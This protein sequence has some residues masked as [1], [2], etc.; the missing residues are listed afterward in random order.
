MPIG[1]ATFVAGVPQPFVPSGGQ[2]W[3]S[4]DDHNLL[5]A[6]LRIGSLAVLMS[7]F[8]LFAGTPLAI[9]YG[10][11][12]EARAV[13]AFRSL[14][15]IILGLGA[16][17]AI[18]D[19][20]LSLGIAIWLREVLRM[21][22]PLLTIM[23]AA[24]ALLMASGTTYLL[25]TKAP[26]IVDGA[27][28]VIALRDDH[29][30]LWRLIDDVA[31]RCRS[32]PPDE[33]LLVPTLE[34][35]TCT[36]RMLT[37]DG[38]RQL[39]LSMPLL[40]VIDEGELR[41]LATYCFAA[42]PVSLETVLHLRVEMVR[43]QP[44]AGMLFEWRSFKP[45]DRVVL[46]I[47]TPLLGIYTFA[48]RCLHVGLSRV[49]TRRESRADE[50]VSNIWG[51]AATANALLKWIELQTIWMLHIEEIWRSPQ[52]R[53]PD[54]AALRSLFQ[55]SLTDS[56]AFERVMWRDRTSPAAPYAARLRSLG[57]GDDAR[58][59]ANRPWRCVGGPSARNL[60]EHPD[61]VE[62]RLV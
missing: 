18:L 37:A 11:R 3:L 49:N 34:L 56:P 40:S 17:A 43:L 29:P 39:R 26:R 7:G 19:A 61:V 57:A 32:K 53:L 22:L 36:R 12:H 4:P 8:I 54:A 10:F 5:R 15:N 41:V 30:E 51:A 38:P 23:F 13:A 48:H 24:A 6:L 47:A 28:G 35:P 33:V 62:A 16:F 50:L 46:A 20:L 42:V 9:A 1:E 58:L 60:I 52:L 59:W 45:F 25:F 44:T 27:S 31:G 55:E 21:G 2:Y 14:V